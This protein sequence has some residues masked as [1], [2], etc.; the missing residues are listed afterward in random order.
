MKIELFLDSIT[1]QTT[2][3]DEDSNIVGSISNSSKHKK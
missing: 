2:L 1:A 3:F